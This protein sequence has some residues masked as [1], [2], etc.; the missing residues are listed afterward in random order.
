M[1]KSG[2]QYNVVCPL[3]LDKDPELEEEV[4][5]S[6]AT[7]HPYKC[8]NQEEVAQVVKN[9]D[10]VITGP[11]EVREKAI[12]GMTRCRIIQALGVGYD[13]VDIE[14]AGERGIYVTNVPDYC[15]NEVADHTIGLLLASSRRILGLVGAAKKGMWFSKLPFDVSIPVSRLEGKTLGLVGLGR[16]GTAVAIRAKAFGMKVLFYDPYLRLGIERSLYLDRSEDLDPLL[17]NS[18][19]I[20]IHTPLTDET[21][22]M[23]GEDQLKRMKKHALI[24]NTARGAIVDRMALFKALKEGWIAGAAL[25]VIEGEPPS[26]DEPILSLENLIITPHRAYYSEESNL[27]CRRKAATNVLRVLQGGIP[28]HIVNEQFLKRL[29]NSGL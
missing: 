1:M 21:Y 23:I 10:A 20:S 16:I 14:S 17:K 15:V 25:D 22:H 24:I 13:R 5:K 7:F 27:D 19:I 26:Q 8:T 12:A 9:A 28:H 29:R 11:I 2:K 3:F 4:L 6:V 18:D